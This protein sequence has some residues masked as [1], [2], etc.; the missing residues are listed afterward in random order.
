MRKAVFLL[1]R[2]SIV[3]FL[4]REMVQR[5]RVTIILYHD[6]GPERAAAHLRALKARYAVIPL[7]AFVEALRERK[8]SA[9]PPKS[10][11]VTFDDGHRGNHA[12]TPVFERL[13]T[14]VTIFLCSRIVGTSRGFWF[15]HEASAERI[16]EL[17]AMSDAEREVRLR[18]AGF[19][20]ERDLP[21][22]QALSAEELR[23]MRDIVDFQSHTMFHPILPHCADDEAGREIVESK[24]DLEAFLG[25]PV[26]ALSYPNGDYSDRDVALARA[27]GYECGITVDAGLNSGATDPFL[28]KRICIGDDDSVTEM[29]VKAS[30][31]WAL[32]KK[33]VMGQEHGRVA[34]EGEGRGHLSRASR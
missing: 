11:V 33:A 19:D 20:K 12:L 10:L 31:L 3:P 23:D 15:L 13:G 14:P 22:R 8:T 30:G 28:L 34:A 7:R 2:A 6:I 32:L 25:R 18:E 26:Y 1:L 9:L 16:A 5:R 24:A 29:L 21:A 4:I 27:A 17:K